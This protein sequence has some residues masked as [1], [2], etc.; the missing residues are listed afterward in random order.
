MQSNL[1]GG[2]PSRGWWRPGTSKNRGVRVDIKRGRAL[3]KEMEYLKKILIPEKGSAYKEGGILI[4]RR[5][6]GN[7]RNLDP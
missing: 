4:P 5:K 2:S 7:R 6:N 3:A 1:R